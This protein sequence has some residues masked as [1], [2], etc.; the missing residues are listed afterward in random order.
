M[1]HFSKLPDGP[2]RF[3][4]WR[5]FSKMAAIFPTQNRFFSYLWTKL[6][7]LHDLG[8]DFGNFYVTNEQ[9]GVRSTRQS[10][11]LILPHLV[12][13]RTQLNIKLCGVNVWKGILEKPSFDCPISVFKTIVLQTLF[14]SYKS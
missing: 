11:D 10:S 4:R 8:V 2:R 9:M 12:K 1:G 7:D 14:D 13:T 6:T 5:P 3:S